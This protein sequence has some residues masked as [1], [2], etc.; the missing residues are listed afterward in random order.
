MNFLDGISYSNS[1]EYRDVFRKITNQPIT[2]PEN[3]H[4]IDDETLDETHYD[5]TIVA[6]FLDEIFQKTRDS[7]IFQS[8][9][10]LAAA[11]M[12][13]T[14]REIGL[15]V[16]FSYDFFDAFYAC[17]CEYVAHPDIFSEKSETYAK[18]R[19]RL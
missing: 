13:S 7:P 8:L 18:M 3:P 4:E 14:D 16:L 15:A 19:N 2:P 11:K 5:E 17:F 1:R 9:Y 12:F 6:A 10:D